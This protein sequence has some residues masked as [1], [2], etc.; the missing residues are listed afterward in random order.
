MVVYNKAIEQMKQENSL[1]YARIWHQA[2]LN[3]L[4]RSENTHLLIGE[5]FDEK[6]SLSEMQEAKEQTGLSFVFF[7]KL[8]LC[9]FFDQPGI[10]IA[11]EGEKLLDSTPAFA[12]TV[13][14]YFYQSL[15]L[16]KAYSQ[17]SKTQQKQIIRKLKNNQ[18]KLK[19]WADYAPMN[20]L[21]K[22]HLVEAEQYRISDNQAK[23]IEFYN[24]A[25]SGAEENE[26]LNEV[27]LTNELARANASKIKLG[28]A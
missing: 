4:G 2:T 13:P 12:T 26:Y 7:L 28:A 9:C 16:T 24:K 25:I 17:A 27:A 5:I 3:L 14:F 20:Y 1:L 10:D 21:H 23:V 19:K 22:W 15:A 8:M 6:Q 11:S 18:K